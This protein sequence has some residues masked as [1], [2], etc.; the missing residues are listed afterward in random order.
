MR[1]GKDLDPS[2]R[3]FICTDIVTADRLTYFSTNAAFYECR[4]WRTLLAKFDVGWCGVPLWSKAVPERKILSD[5]SH[6]SD[7]LF[8]AI[9]SKWLLLRKKTNIGLQ[10][11]L[12]MIHFP[13]LRSGFIFR[14]RDNNNLLFVLQNNLLFLLKQA[15]STYNKSSFLLYWNPLSKKDLR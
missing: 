8:K 15:L 11:F 7:I 12:L 3:P 5:S 14:I 6:N 1:V 13:H 2:F 10:C 4:R 9:R